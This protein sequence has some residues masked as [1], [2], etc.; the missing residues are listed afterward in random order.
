MARLRE[1]VGYWNAL[2]LI[3]DIALVLGL[4]L[5]ATRARAVARRRGRCW[6]T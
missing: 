6:L 2:A 3:A 4:W 5:G 1:P